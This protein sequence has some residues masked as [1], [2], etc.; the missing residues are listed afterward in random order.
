MTYESRGSTAFK[1]VQEFKQKLD[2]QNHS[3]MELILLYCQVNN[4]DP[5]EFGEELKRDKNFREMFKADLIHHHE[6]RFDGTKKDEINEWVQLK[7]DLC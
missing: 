4:K 2:I 5:G 6:A 7:G 1:K 3:M